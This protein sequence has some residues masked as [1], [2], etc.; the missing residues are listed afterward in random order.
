MKIK[1]IKTEKE[2]DLAC[3]KVYKLCQKNP[4][5]GSA[6]GDE[7]ELLGI[8]IDAYQEEHYHFPPP[9]PIEAIKFRMDQMNFKQKDIAPIFGG[10]SRISKVL[11]KKRPLTMKMI[12]NLNHY[13]GIPFDSL[14]NENSNNSKFE[15]NSTAKKRL[16]ENI[17]PSKVK[18]KELA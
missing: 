16:L 3:S 17:N 9:D 11:N 18:K 15:L 1:P 14:I 12:Y 7:I 4:K 10:E 13:L 2:Y 8:L 5:K 6:I